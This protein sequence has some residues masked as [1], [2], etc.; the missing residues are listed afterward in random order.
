MRQGQ[1]NISGKLLTGAITHHFNSGIEVSYNNYY[2]DFY[3]SFNITGYDDYGNHVPFN[4]YSPVHG[5]IP[6]AAL[7]QFD[8]TRSLKERGYYRPSLITKSLY[9][10]DELHFA[11]DK[12][13]MTIGARY[14]WV[15][16]RNYE[17][18]SNDQRLTPRI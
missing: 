3:Q 9:I 12:A 15:T 7:P 14:S 6:E 4:I 2:A 18:F 17:I 11:D 5:I 10:H 13:R 16:Q 1:I 8:R